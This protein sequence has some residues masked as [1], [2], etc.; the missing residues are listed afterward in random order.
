MDTRRIVAIAVALIVAI[1][2]AACG[3]SDEEQTQP[4]PV[5]ATAEPDAPSPADF[6]SGGGAPQP[7]SPSA[8]AAAAPR[9][10]DLARIALGLGDLPDGASIRFEGFVETE[11]EI[12]AFRR[13]LDTFD[14]QIGN[15]RILNLVNDVVLFESAEVALLALEQVRAE[16]TERPGEFFRGAIE[17]GA[18]IGSSNFSG[19]TAASPNSAMGR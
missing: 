16:L 5:P 3:S 10:P 18:G 15:S 13:S 6:A 19:Q 11:D 4:D 17:E 7:Q 12:V 8:D 1:G 2:G 14:V 9:P